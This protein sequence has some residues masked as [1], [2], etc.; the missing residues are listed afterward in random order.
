MHIG[1]VGGGIAGSVAARDL[2]RLGVTVTVLDK[3]RGPGGRMSSRRSAV[4]RF[5][6]GVGYFEADTDGFRRWLAPWA[7]DGVVTQWHPQG[8]SA[9]VWV[10]LPKMNRLVS[11]LQKDLSVSYEARVERVVFERGV[12]RVYRQ[13]IPDAVHFDSLI[14]AIPAPQ[15]HLLLSGFPDLQAELARV[16][17]AP[18]WSIMLQYAQPL[19]LEDAVVHDIGPILRAV[20]EAAK[21][22]RSDAERWVIQMNEAWTR[23]H[24]EWDSPDILEKVVDLF[25][26]MHGQKVS[27]RHA[28][29][30]RW[31]YSTVSSAHEAPFLVSADGTLGICGDGFGGSGIGAA[32]RSAQ[33]LTAS[34]QRRIQ[35]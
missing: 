3:A 23:E 14:L 12:W 1:I 2:Q 7:E 31:R 8:C 5:D 4:G 18:C 29:A 35:Q 20:N 9:P 10:A 25:Q 27:V 22:G 21:P 26:A 13:G 30:H 24:L 34:F 19:G 15:A 11:A 17:Y 16:V 32:V 28:T 6:H 33:A